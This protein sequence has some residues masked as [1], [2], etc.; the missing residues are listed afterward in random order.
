M[1]EFSILLGGLFSG[2][3]IFIFYNSYYT[4]NE[5]K[6]QYNDKIVFLIEFF[7]FVSENNPLLLDYYNSN[8]D[9]DEATDESE[10][11]L[12]KMEEKKE[13]ERFEEKYLVKFNN[14]PNEY[15]FSETELEEETKEYEI[16]KRQEAKKGISVVS[17]INNELDK[18]NIIIRD[19]NF[20]DDTDKRFTEN[21]NE[22]G[23]N[24]LV[25]YFDLEDDYEDDHDNIDLEE[26]YVELL[27]TQLQLEKRM[28]EAKGSI[29]S[30]DELRKITR[31][32]IINNKLEKLINNYILEHTPL[33][34]IY[35]RYNNFKGSFEYFSNNTIP[36]RYLEP[37]GRKYA[38]TY[39]CKPIFF[40]INDELKKAEINYDE[41][42]KKGDEKKEE[43]KKRELDPKNNYKS[44]VAKMKSYNTD[45]KSQS[46]NSMQNRS[47]N[48]V[49]PPQIKANLPSVNQTSE[50]QLLKENAN[51]YTWE[52]RLTG[53][54]PLK[55]V[56]MKVVDKNL[57]LS[58]ADFK[59]LQAKK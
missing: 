53:F 42:K 14:F 51:R 43:D 10:T 28:K 50:K 58:Y 41:E 34:N 44:I 13:K 7:K 12:T 25:K 2:A 9:D 49:L 37:V 24:S 15:S 6:K 39:C 20:T 46:I 56:D 54:S 11:Q 47:K 27:T 21:I 38:M 17:D 59:K 33:G 3:Y 40:D 29:L 26:L 31:N 52:G 23:I 18:I 57:S 45:K 35:M 1:Y 55:K 8:H 36:Y 5:L 30:D 32:K 16:L 19:G 48:N 4:S 22:F